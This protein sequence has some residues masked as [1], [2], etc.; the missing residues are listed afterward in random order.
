MKNNKL[1]IIEK[2]EIEG[3]YSNKDINILE[4]L[5]NDKSD[6]VRARVAE[7][8]YF[9]SPELSQNILIKLSND[10]DELVRVNAC[11]SLSN[12]NSTNVFILLKE[13]ACRDNSNLVRGYSIFSVAN[14]AR[15]K[16]VTDK[17]LIRFFKSRLIKE[18][19]IWVKIN[20]Y[21]ALYLLGE[22]SFIYLII[23]ELNNRLY[24]NRCVVVNLLTYITS[25]KN[26]RII[27]DAL[28][29]R[30]KIEKTLAVKS[31][32]NNALKEIKG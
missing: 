6:E 29:E 15:R 20:L 30:L 2:I 17:E 26:Q 7:I 18:K 21:C 32:I 31:S 5:S 1:D 22:D 12:N 8:L 3:C 27:I 13:K 9:Y 10:K 24:R 25:S 19:I 11:E 28:D 14:I 4:E 23:K 16:K